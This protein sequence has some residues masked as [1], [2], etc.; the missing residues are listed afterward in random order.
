ML[1]LQVGKSVGKSAVVRAEGGLE[2]RGCGEGGIQG[3]ER[4]DRHG[5]GQDAHCRGGQGAFT[6]VC[7]T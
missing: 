2:G 7:L 5:E 6:F 3:V 1:P 4:I